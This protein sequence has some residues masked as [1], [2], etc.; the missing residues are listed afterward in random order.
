MINKIP[1]V[2]RGFATL[3]CDALYLWALLDNKIDNWF[4]VFPYAIS[5]FLAWA[6]NGILYGVFA[7]KATI[8]ATK[9]ASKYT[10][11]IQP[12]ASSLKQRSRGYWIMQ[13]IFVAVWIGVTILKHIEIANMH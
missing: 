9:E 10:N 6:N 2:V 3:I 12:G 4:P 5:L 13:A 11:T 7:N 8:D 1:F